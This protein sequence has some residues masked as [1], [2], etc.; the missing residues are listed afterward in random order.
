MRVLPK[1]DVVIV[2]LGA[3]GGVAAEVLTKAGLK[4]VGLEAG[5][6]LTNKDF[7]KQLDEISGCFTRNDLGERKFNKEVPTWRPNPSTPAG[8]SPIVWPMMNAVGGTSVHYGAQSWRLAPGDFRVRSDTIKRY[9][10]EALP[11]EATIADWPLSYDDLE[12]YYDRV[13][14]SIGVS[15]RGGSN[16]FEGPRTRDYPMPPLRTTGYCKSA[17]SAMRKLGYHPFP[18]PAAI[19]SIHRDGR[20][21][22]SYCGFCSGFGCWNDSKSSTLVTSIKTAEQTGRL[23]VRA[24][25]AVT[26]IAVDRSG[27]VSGVDYRTEAG[28]VVHQPAKFVIL[29]SFVYENVR[30]LLLSTS[31]AFPNGLSNNHKQVGKN[32]LSHGY[33]MVSGLFPG[34]NLRLFN[35][36]TGQAVAIDDLNGDNFDH[37]GL[38][39]IRGAMVFTFNQNMPIAAANALPPDVPKW[40]QG[41]KDWLRK[42]VNSV[43]TMYSQ[44]ETLPYR[45]NYLDLDSAKTDPFGDR[46]IR[47]TYDFQDNERRAGAFIAERLEKILLAMGATKTW[48]VMP[49]IP[50]PVN[51]HA[52]GGT[53]MGHDPAHSVVDRNSLSHEVR[54]LAILGGSTFVTISGYNP[55]Q[56]IQALSW[57]SAEHIAANFS[58]LTS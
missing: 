34:R 39:F 33:V 1:T 35:G 10:E 46:V 6:Y 18:Q 52:Y 32:Y 20:A 8:D 7:I 37:K 27:K 29:S 51:T 36:T 24:N 44:L 48:L 57:R 17:A 14:Y 58:R 11:A 47:A 49:A 9:G 12:P 23:E 19:N 43:G 25:S 54:N 30:R 45:G 53:R 15:G 16:P 31:E 50:V 21:A 55:T 5:P 2:G 3:A 42:N 13:E 28:E 26:R 4:A 56:T 40:G 38:G 22:C 41:Y